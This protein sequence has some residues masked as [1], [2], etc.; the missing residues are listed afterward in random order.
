MSLNPPLNPQNEPI[1]KEGESLI[2]QKVNI[3][4]EITIS[5]NKKLKGKNKCILTT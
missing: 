1:L 3:E 5:F 4:F 2:L